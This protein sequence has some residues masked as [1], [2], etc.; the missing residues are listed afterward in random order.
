MNLVRAIITR[1]AAERTLGHFGEPQTRE[2]QEARNALAKQ[3][4]DA[5]TAVDDLSQARRSNKRRSSRAAAKWWTKAAT[6]RRPPKE[7]RRRCHRPTVP[8]IQH[9]RC[10]RLGQGTRTTPSAA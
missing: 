4:R 7:G 3:K 2:G 1:E 10:Q 9:R 5:D 6:P 8:Q